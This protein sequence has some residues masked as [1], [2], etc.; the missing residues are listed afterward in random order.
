MTP[1]SADR[2]RDLPA[3]G[4]GLRRDVDELGAR[5]RRL[6]TGWLIRCRKEPEVATGYR[7]E[8]LR[9]PPP[10]ARPAPKASGADG[11][12]GMQP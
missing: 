6:I 11:G 4:A 5:V 9:L 7:P 8:E 1:Y 2:T 3:E 12:G 10:S